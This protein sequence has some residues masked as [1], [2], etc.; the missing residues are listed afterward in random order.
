MAV[1]GRTL[2]SSELGGCPQ[3]GAPLAGT[4]G[5]PRID[6]PFDPCSSCGTFVGRL[7]ANEWELL[8]LG[9]KTGHIARHA[10]RAVS[11]GLVP[12]TL[13][14]LVTVVGGQDWLPTETLVWL[15]AGWV[16]FGAIEGARLGS[17]IQRSRRRMADPMYRARLVKYELGTATRR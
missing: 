12:A 11:F 16:G 5:V 8:R 10:F 17:R 2:G 9:E 13:H 6:K 14:L 15:V 3:C 7:G 1:A 4:Q